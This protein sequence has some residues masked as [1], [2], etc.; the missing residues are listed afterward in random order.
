MTTPLEIVLSYHRAWTSQDFDLAMTYLADDMVC[1]AP[2]G[3]LVGAE[4]FR[5]FMEPFSQILVSSEL[6]GSFGDETT[7]MLMYDTSTRPVA[8]A[9]GAELHTVR[10][11]KIVELRIIFDRLPFEQARTVAA[12]R[13]APPEGA[14]T[15]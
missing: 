12:T 13:S 1:H 10:D 14:Q 3:R 15:E 7:A 9:P 2:A 4:A 11:G 6:V 5:G 8:D